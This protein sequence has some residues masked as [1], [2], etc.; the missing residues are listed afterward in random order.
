MTILGMKVPKARQTYYSTIM[1]LP[2][3][4]KMAIFGQN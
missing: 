1:D 2:K 4:A 3:M